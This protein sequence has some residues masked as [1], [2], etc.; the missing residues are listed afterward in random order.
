MSGT[1][2]KQAY[3]LKMD[4]RKF[5]KSITPKD[6]KKAKKEL[7]KKLGFSART[8]EKRLNAMG[9]QV[10]RGNIKKQHFE[11]GILYVDDY[12]QVIVFS[13]PATHQVSIVNGEVLISP[14][15]SNLVLSNNKIKSV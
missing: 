7:A 1:N 9:M 12:R 3:C 13:I 6:I 15:G 8:R 14:K 4:I 11:E 2:R 10:R 5:Y